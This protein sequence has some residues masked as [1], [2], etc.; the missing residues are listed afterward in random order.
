MKSDDELFQL[1]RETADDMA[2]DTIDESFKDYFGYDPNLPYVEGDLILTDEEY[3]RLRGMALKVQA[4]VFLTPQVYTDDWQDENIWPTCVEWA[5]IHGIEPKLLA[6][7]LEDAG[8]NAWF[9]PDELDVT[10][11]KI[12]QFC[13]V[14]FGLYRALNPYTEDSRLYGM[15]D[16]S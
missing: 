2:N 1:L 11:E 14:N 9:P 13:A 7:I 6:G 15:D 5:R 4:N 10:Q 16:E 8:E 3:A 12:F